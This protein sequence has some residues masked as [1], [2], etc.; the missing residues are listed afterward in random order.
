MHSEQNA[1]KMIAS[2]KPTDSIDWFLSQFRCFFA[3]RQTMST[4][5]KDF[6]CEIMSEQ[7]VEDFVQSNRKKGGES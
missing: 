2:A 6:S 1:A 4:K 3:M 7:S 5:T